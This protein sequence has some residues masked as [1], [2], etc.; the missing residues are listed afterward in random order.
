MLITK[1]KFIAKTK[2]TSMLH[3]NNIDMIYIHI[4][5]GYI[6]NCIPKLFKDEQMIQSTVTCYQILL[7]IFQK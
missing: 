5:I 7:Y 6:C 3:K 1:N 2:V 4:V